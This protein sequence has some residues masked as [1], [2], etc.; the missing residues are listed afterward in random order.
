[1]RK[2]H[3]FKFV[4]LLTFSCSSLFCSEPVE[5]LVILGGGP[6]G[7]T[8]AIYAGQAGLAPLVV[9]KGECT[10]QLTAVNHIENYPGFLKE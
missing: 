2:Y 8:A 10:G 4:M 3:F 5:R 1:M 7:L 9:K 6:A